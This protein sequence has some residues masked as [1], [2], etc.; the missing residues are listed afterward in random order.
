MKQELNDQALQQVI[1][2]VAGTK[3][4]MIEQAPQLAKEMIAYEIWESKFLIGIGLTL[5]TIGLV[6]IISGILSHR[7]QKSDYVSESQ[8]VR[9]AIGGIATVIAVC[10]TMVNLTSLKAVEI[11]PRAYIVKKILSAAK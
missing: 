5:L 7:K 8:F 4:F 1:Q 9:F 6:L 10:M 3:D 2:I 11:S